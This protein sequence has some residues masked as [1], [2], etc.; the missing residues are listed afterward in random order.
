VLGVVDPV[1]LHETVV[2]L[3]PGQT[4]LLYTDGLPE[5]GRATAQLDEPA[6]LAL[7]AQAHASTLDGLLGRIEQI[8]L[9]RAEGR[10]RD[11]IALLALRISPAVFP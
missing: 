11:D 2:E 3:V 4:L 9:E 5:A 6:L 7:C 10:L 8:A 1:V